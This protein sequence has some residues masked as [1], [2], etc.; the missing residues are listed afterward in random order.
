M[1]G[2]EPVAWGVFNREHGDLQV[3]HYMP[4]GTVSPRQVK[5]PLFTL[6][7]AAAHLAADLR[8]DGLDAVDLRA[9]LSA[10]WGP[11]TTDE[12]RDQATDAITDTVGIVAEW[13]STRA[14]LAALT[15]CACPPCP[16]RGNDGHGM[17]H[18]AECCFGSGVEADVDCPT[19]GTAALITPTEET[20]A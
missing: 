12:E 8:S 14:A 4:G 16:G 2:A 3:L 7:A 17:E 1:S 10:L 5:E 19:H 6:N 9:D 15:A 20:R 11:G 13:L 18:C